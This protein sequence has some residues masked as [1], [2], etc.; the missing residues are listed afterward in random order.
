MRPFNLD[1]Y[2]KN[3]N[4]KI[5]TRDKRS[6][7]IICTNK[8]SAQGYTVVALIDNSEDSYK[9]TEGA[10]IYT[11]EGKFNGVYA[12]RNDLFFALEKKEVWIN[13]YKLESK[14]I[15]DEITYN[16]KEEALN[17]KDTTMNYVGTFKL[18]FEE[19]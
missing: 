16:T 4:K 12:D 15:V 8:K 11:P 3:P 5:V 6:V 9:D 1:E 2:L 17:N 19:E 18:E 7:R 14:F 10:A 13:V